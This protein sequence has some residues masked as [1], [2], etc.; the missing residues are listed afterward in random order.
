MKLYL[1]FENEIKLIYFLINYFV[2]KEKWKEIFN[3]V[4]FDL[5]IDI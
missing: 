4:V 3:I 2:L 1:Y 5:I